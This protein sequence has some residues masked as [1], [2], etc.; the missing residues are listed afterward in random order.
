MFAGAKVFPEFP[1][2]LPEAKHC[3]GGAFPSLRSTSSHYVHTKSRQP[4]ARRGGGR[5]WAAVGSRPCKKS[6]SVAFLSYIMVCYIP[7]LPPRSP[8]LINPLLAVTFAQDN[9][10]RMSTKKRLSLPTVA[11]KCQRYTAW[12]GAGCPP[13]GEPMLID[14]NRRTTPPRRGASPP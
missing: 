5:Q 4:L 13:R 7:S 14:K 1:E 11:L 3:G 12:N 9:P 2:I 6:G 8:N 10:V